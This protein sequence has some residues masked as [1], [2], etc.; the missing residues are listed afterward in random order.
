MK[1]QDI[2]IHWLRSNNKDEYADH[3]IIELLKE[4]EIKWKSMTSYNLS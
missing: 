1:T 4:H 3:Q 2:S